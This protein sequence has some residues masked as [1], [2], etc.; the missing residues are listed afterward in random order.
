MK[1]ELSLLH[2]LQ[3]VLVKHKLVKVLP[4]DYELVIILLKLVAE[5]SAEKVAEAVAKKNPIKLNAIAILKIKSRII[6]AL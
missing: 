5:T 1:M 3:V 6:I 2:I 4:M